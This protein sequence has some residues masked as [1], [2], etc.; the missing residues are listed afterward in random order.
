MYTNIL[1]PLDGSTIAQ[2]VLPYARAVAAALGIPV[3]ILQVMDPVTLIPSVAAQQGR[4]H[5]ILTINREHNGDY[6]KEI[7]ASF[8]NPA[9][10]SSSVRVGKP[11][12]VIIEVAATERDTLIAMAT[13]GR[14]GIRRW[15]LGSVA[16]KVL[17]GADNDVLLIRAIGQ[18]E[19]TEA[20]HLE[21]LVVPLD[22]SELA[23]KALPRAVELAK[24]MT[25]ELILLR[26]Y[27]MPGVAYPTGNYAPDWKLLDQ[28][29]RERASEYLEGK[30]RELRNEGLERVSFRVLEGSAAEKIIEVAQESPESL[31]A[32]S[33]HGASGVGRWV[34][35]SVTE[36][37]VRHSDAA[38]LVVRAKRG[39]SAS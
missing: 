21:R 19:R 35:G 32:M 12:E 1:V 25:L 2:G 24:K 20:A 11:A 38:V 4:S 30:I 23:E 28:E 5:N 17:H 16:E 18:I 39:S 15:L 22:G 34:L 8:C 6:L 9:A 10:V 36:R 37:V 14:S 7:A 3:H 33:T 27:L 13:H 31:I 26:V 29:T